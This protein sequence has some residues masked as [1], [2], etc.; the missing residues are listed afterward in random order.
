MAMG[1]IIGSAVVPVALSILMETA[2][3]N[4]CTL[5]AVAGFVIAMFA[6]VMS[7]YSQ[8]DDPELSICVCFQC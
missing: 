4:A 1:N 8:F 5:A 3:G 6:W 2:N 7:A